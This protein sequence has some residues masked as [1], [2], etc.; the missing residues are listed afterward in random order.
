MPLCVPLEDIY[1]FF[2]RFHQ[3]VEWL[4][5]HEVFTLLLG[6]LFLLQSQDRFLVVWGWREQIPSSGRRYMDVRPP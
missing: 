1:C 4:Q 2:L 6:D 3:R 5:F